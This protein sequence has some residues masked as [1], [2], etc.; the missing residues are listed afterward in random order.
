[1]TTPTP[2]P[3]PTIEASMRSTY[4]DAVYVRPISF[5]V[6][7]LIKTVDYEYEIENDEYAGNWPVAVLPRSGEF[8]ASFTRTF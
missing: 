4:T 1:M 5:T 7:K 8:T 2:T 6:N 3:T